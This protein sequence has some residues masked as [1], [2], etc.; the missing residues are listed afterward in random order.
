MQA[1]FET[2]LNALNLSAPQHFHNLTLFPLQTELVPQLPYIMLSTALE[3]HWLH[4]TE[5]NEG[6]SVP[7]L[8]VHNESEHFILLLD[9]EEL[10]GAKQNRVLNTSILVPPS[11]KMQI[12]VSCTEQRRWSYKSHKFHKSEHLMF[13]KARA[14]KMAQ[15]SESL[16]SSRTYDSQ[17]GEVWHDIEELHANLRVRSATGAMSDV[18]EERKDHLQDYLDAFAY[19]ACSQGMLVGLNGKVVGLE[20]LSR[21]ENFELL[22]PQL[23]ESYAMDALGEADPIKPSPLSLETAQRYLEQLWGTKGEAFEAKGAGMNLRLES[24]TVVGAALLEQEEVIHFSSFPREE[25]I[26]SSRHSFRRTQIRR[27]SRRARQQQSH[28]TK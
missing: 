23:L 1:C 20:Y 8:R 21:P 24:S 12:P 13:R 10:A 17:Q 14:K 18:F 28:P 3:H 2:T 22:F 11:S 6:G 16:K 25:E 4:I 27:A 7:E 19:V 15:V 9:G 5:I 26:D